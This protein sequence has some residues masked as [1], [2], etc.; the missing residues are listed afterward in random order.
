MLLQT[1]FLRFKDK[2]DERK[3]KESFL[4]YQRMCLRVLCLTLATQSLVIFIFNPLEIDVLKPILIFTF[5]MMI[6]SLGLIFCLYLKRHYQRA[7]LF[8]LVLVIGFISG[9]IEFFRNHL[10]ERGELTPNLYF[11]F[12]VY[13]QTGCL[14]IIIARIEW[15]K[16]SLA[17]IFLQ[18]HMW[19]RAIDPTTDEKSSKP[20]YVSL[21]LYVI[22]LPLVCYFRER[23][24]RIRFVKKQRD[25]NHLTM[26]QN[27]ITDV[28][29][30]AVVILKGETVTFF[31][32]KTKDVLKVSDADGLLRILGMIKVNE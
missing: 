22:I 14:Y 11:S 12:G 21:S 17:I 4:D 31:N 13:L 1:K 15:L 19:I 32:E 3:F 7:D 2:F 6:L 29:P 20:I 16:S 26:F 28:L 23:E 27:L 25:E 10:I 9:A 18:L 30:N 8:I 5:V 24:D